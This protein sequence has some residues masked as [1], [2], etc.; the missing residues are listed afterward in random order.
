MNNIPSS[1]QKY[2]KISA[3]KRN[4]WLVSLIAIIISL[5]GFIF[6]WTNP[7]IKAP[8]RPGLDFTGGTQIRLERNCID[9]SCNPINS[10]EII[11]TIKINQKDFNN[12]STQISSSS[13][14]VQFIDGY[15]SSG[16][17]NHPILHP[18]IK[19]YLEKL[20][21]MIAFLLF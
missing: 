9:Q 6:S 18:V 7:E 16:Q 10:N 21:I 5:L 13:I 8:L 20:L 11:D 3:N 15:K 14:K 4:I 17:I 1:N 19:K 2:L 12:E